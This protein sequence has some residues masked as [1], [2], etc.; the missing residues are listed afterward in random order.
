MKTQ[1]EKNVN[2]RTHKKFKGWK[3]I[4]TA[5]A[6]INKSYKIKRINNAKQT[7]KTTHCLQ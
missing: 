5:D 4:K 6:C 2:G 3:H 1:Y 7:T